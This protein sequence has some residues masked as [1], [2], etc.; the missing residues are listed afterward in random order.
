MKH[1][2]TAACCT[3]IQ[4]GCGV[5]AAQAPE[6][7]APE[8]LRPAEGEVLLMSLQ[9][10]GVQ[11]YECTLTRRASN[12]YEWVLVEPDA[13]LYDAHKRQIGWHDAGPQWHAKD[14]SAIVGTVQ[15]RASAPV[16]GAIPWLLLSA[17]SVGK[18]GVFSKVT[19]IQ[20]VNTSGGTA[21]TARCGD[22]IEGD[23][24][25]VGYSAE[26]RFYGSGHHVAQR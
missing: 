7:T 24:A 4:L 26:Y 14:G 6:T 10:Q 9:A 13:K 17:R 12:T 21:P 3:L 2:I 22:E 20:R 19:S 11:V 16:P 1:L 8:A 15:Q 23:T 5:A 25:R 18:A